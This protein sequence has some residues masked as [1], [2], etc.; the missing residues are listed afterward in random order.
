[1]HK[2]VFISD[3][4]AG[5]I[6]V[7]DYQGH[8]TGTIAN[9]PGVCD[10][11]LSGASTPYRTASRTAASPVGHSTGRSPHRRATTNP[12]TPAPHTG[13]THSAAPDGSGRRSRSRTCCPARRSGAEPGGG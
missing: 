11:E 1:M 12:A 10:L 5:T 13:F 7:A 6:L 4:N 2:R 8:L 3:Y 9:L